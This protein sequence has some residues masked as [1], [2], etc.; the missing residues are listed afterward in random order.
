[1]GLTIVPL[2]ESSGRTIIATLRAGKLVGLLSD[3]D[4]AG[5]GV[6]VEVFGGFQLHP[7]KY[8]TKRKRRHFAAPDEFEVSCIAGKS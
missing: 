6:E 2:D 1:M 4:V 3:R 8:P 5:N 7:F